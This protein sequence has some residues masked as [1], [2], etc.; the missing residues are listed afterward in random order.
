MTLDIL[1][2]RNPDAKCLCWKIILFSQRDEKI[3]GTLISHSMAGRWL[4]SK[5]IPSQKDHE[6]DDLI[7]SSPGLSIWKKSFPSQSGVD[8]T[9]CLS[10]VRETKFDNLNTTASGASAILFLISESIPWKHQKAQL[11]KLVMSIPNGSRLPLLI[12]SFSNFTG[13]SDPCSTIINEL[14]LNDIDRSRVNSFWVK[15]LIDNQQTGHSDEFFSDEQ[16]REG[17]KWLASES[18]PQPVVF[19]VKTREII[20]SHLSSNLEALGKLSDHEV[21]PNHCISAFNEALNRSLD[22]IEA[23][24]RSNPVNWPCHEIELVEDSNYN[25]FIAKSYL[26]SIGWSSTVKIESFKCALRDLKLPMF[27]D[28]IIALLSKG[29]NMGKE[30][31]NQRLQLQDYLTK[32]L[33]ELT[34][35]M[36]IAMATKEASI[37]LERSSSLELHDSSYYCIVPKWVMIFQQAFNWRLMSLTNGELSS[38][39]VSRHQPSST[40]TFGDLE[41]SFYCLSHPSLDE[42]IEV[43]CSPI[44]TQKT[45]LWP[46]I[47][48]PLPQI[49]S[50]GQVEEPAEEINLAARGTNFPE[51]HG[52]LPLGHDV[53]N[54]NCKSN[55]TTGEK[56]VSRYVTKEADSLS[57]LL[58][59]CN[60]MQSKNEKKLYVYF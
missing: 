52:R 1:S 18:P 54:I 29:S 46:Q 30:I 24:A 58:E 19:C 15:I 20:L 40:P 11:H 26:P 33:T 37:M 51:E 13:L 44:K 60:I 41:P 14:G 2:R 48:Q 9:H 47:G 10:V 21:G 34:R 43:G 56:P 12:L 16:L 25:H 17:L 3:Q 55:D 42:I 57:E 6:G 50:Y 38:A 22:E 59:R 4:S 7:V 8:Q 36:G 5:L 28:D 32:Y 23:T 53:C 31:E 35:M 49:A 39:Y 45:Q 27:A